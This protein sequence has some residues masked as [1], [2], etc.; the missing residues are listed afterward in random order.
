MHEIFIPM[1]LCSSIRLVE[2]Y[3]N[4]KQGGHDV[5]PYD[6]L[7]DLPGHFSRAFTALPVGFYFYIL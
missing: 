2:G 6:F 5:L 1:M 4:S 3:E 7:I